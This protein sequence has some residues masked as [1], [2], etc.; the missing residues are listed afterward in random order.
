MWI[1]P[2]HDKS[3]EKSNIPYNLHINQDNVDA[4]IESGNKCDRGDDIKEHNLD[5]DETND[6]YELRV[7]LRQINNIGEVD[8]GMSS[9]EVWTHFFG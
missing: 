2:L 9:N 4:E 7:E 8:H 5:R 6:G 3:I 1:W